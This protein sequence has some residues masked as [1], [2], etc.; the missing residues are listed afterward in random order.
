M[1]TSDQGSHPGRIVALVLGCIA[2]LPALGMLLAG[3]AL[4]AAYAFGR[5]DDGFFEVH[6]DDLE[7]STAALTA[8]EIDLTTD[9]GTPGWLVDSLDADVRLTLTPV[10][11][12]R[13]M[14]LGIGPQRDVDA[15]LSTVAH[16]EIRSFDGGEP[17]LRRRDGDADADP[18]TDQDLWVA[19]VSGSGSQELLWE[20]GSGRWAVV[21]MNADGS[22]GVAA[23]VVVGAKADFVLPL[24]LLM[25]VIGGLGLVVAVVLIV[26]GAHGL[27]GGGEAPPPPPPLAGDG[28]AT[29]QIVPAPHPLTIEAPLDPE[30]SRWQWLV[31]WLLA[32][33]HLIVLAFLWLAL[34]VTTFVAGIAILVTGR[35]PSS[36]FHFAV[37][38]LRWSWR[39]D[40]YAF[41]GGPGTD[42]YPPFS[43]APDDSYPA[44]LEVVEPPRLSRGLVLVKWWLLAIPQYLVVAILVGGAW[45]TGSVDEPQ[46]TLGLLSLL[47]FVAVVVLLFRG[48]YPRS[49]FDLVV[50]LNRWI[51]RVAVY[52]LL[53]TDE[54]PPFRLDQG[55]TEPGSSFSETGPPR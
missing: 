33:P 9:P 11:G 34:V 13:E 36:L 2:V 29:G 38:V 23:D 53:L 25:L 8:E 44:R 24:G 30:L 35:Y 3:G 55:P 20:V 19:S 15:Y 43:L 49:L 14:F 28:A 39:V 21:V 51:Y 6:V 10:D 22:A 17:N 41:S 42:R 50:G 7:T 40:F 54:Y 16:D 48:A 4:S 26:F 45:G 12:D 46:G 37:G 47:A 27:G 31:K 18:P 32:I 52:A 5:D 1:S